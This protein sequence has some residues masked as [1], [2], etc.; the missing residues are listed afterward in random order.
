MVGRAVREYCLSAGDLVFPYDH[1]SLDIGDAARVLQTLQ[2]DQP[3]VVINC[4]AWTDVDGCEIDRE[5]AFV[6]NARG[7][8]NLA[9]ASREIRAV[10][11]TISTDYVFRGDKE[12]STLREV[13]PR[14]GA[15]NGVQKLGVNVA[16]SWPMP[17]PWWFVPGLSSARPERIS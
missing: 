1:Q 9:N 4:A 2:N 11:V 13:N 12:V 6:A 10:L 14:R 15:F 17:A 16:P 3:E 8:E 7:P 5:R